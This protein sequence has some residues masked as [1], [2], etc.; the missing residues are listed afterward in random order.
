MKTTRHIS[1]SGTLVLSSTN[2][3]AH[4]FVEVGL[5]E[6]QGIEQ[7]V[8]C[9]QLDVVARLLLPHALN[10][11]RQDLVGILLQLLWIL[12]GRQTTTGLEDLM[13]SHCG[14]FSA[15]WYSQCPGRCIRWPPVWTP[16]Y[17]RCWTG[18]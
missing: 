18:P 13:T 3:T 12:D 9:R 17:V 2:L 11:C 5:G 10:D 8:G 4:L 15:Q 7:G 6:L 14:H 16:S 1:I